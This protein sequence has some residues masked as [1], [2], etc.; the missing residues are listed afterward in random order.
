MPWS[1]SAQ[2]AGHGWHVGPKNPG[3]QVSQ[4]VPLN[5]GAQR[6]VPDEEHVPELAHGDEQVEDCMSRREMD[7]ELL[8]GS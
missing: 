3:A 5:P 4:D 7:P 2:P 1:Q 6:Q 8:E